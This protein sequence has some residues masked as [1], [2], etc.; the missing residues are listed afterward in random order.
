MTRSKSDSADPKARGDK[1]DDPDDEAAAAAA[2]ERATDQAIAALSRR[3]QKEHDRHARKRERALVKDAV[4][5]RADERIVLSAAAKDFTLADSLWRSQ[6]QLASRIEAFVDKP[7]LALELARALREV[8]ACRGATT[9]RAEQLVL[10][11]STMR[12]QRKLAN[13]ETK[14]PLRRVA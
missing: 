9:A 4:G 3:W 7:K 10:A 14:P 12:A 8:T 13:P 6:V 1:P 11:A 5:A 2:E